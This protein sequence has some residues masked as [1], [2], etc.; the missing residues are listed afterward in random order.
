MVL[1]CVASIALFWYAIFL[2]ARKAHVMSR[3]YQ[4]NLPARADAWQSLSGISPMGDHYDSALLFR[5]IYE[6]YEKNV[7]RI[8]DG[9]PLLRSVVIDELDAVS[10]YVSNLLAL[11]GEQYD[12]VL[13][14]AQ[15]Y[16]VRLLIDVDAPR[17][18]EESAQRLAERAA[19]LS[20]VDSR[21]QELLTMLKKIRLGRD[22]LK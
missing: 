15:L 22:V 11:R 19:E 16:S 12:L 8:R 4:M 10:G 20:P 18:I 9:D 6:E 1:A 5:E 13:I 3:V 21:P 14:A 17:E 2:P 7:A